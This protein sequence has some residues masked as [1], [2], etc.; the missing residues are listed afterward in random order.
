MFMYRNTKSGE[1]KLY[2]IWNGILA[3]YSFTVC[4]PGAICWQ[5][6]PFIIQVLQNH[7]SDV[8]SQIDSLEPATLQTDI[9]LDKSNSHICKNLKI[10]E[11]C[12]TIQSTISS[13][14]NIWTQSSECEG[15]P[16]LFQRN[17]TSA[18]NVTLKVNTST[19]TNVTL[20]RRTAEDVFCSTEKL[21]Q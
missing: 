18:E 21:Q 2:K 13:T 6:H 20:T 12:L 4:L 17:I 1:K 10:D 11:A 19:E 9:L 15:C 16:V 14:L 7:K 8:S 5:Q 3:V